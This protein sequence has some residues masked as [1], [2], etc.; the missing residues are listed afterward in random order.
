MIAH[1]III[2]SI[3][4]IFPGIRLLY[5]SAI[6]SSVFGGRGQIPGKK[7]RCHF[8]GKMGVATKVKSRLWKMCPYLYIL[9]YCLVSK[10][11]ANFHAHIETQTMQ[12]ADS[13]CVDWVLHFK[14][15]EE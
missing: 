1:Y 15:L 7:G 5:K 14:L 4:Y 11:Q 10:N 8:L 12:N 9:Y 2:I 3:Y 6:S 13:L